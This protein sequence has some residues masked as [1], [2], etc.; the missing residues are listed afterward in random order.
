L[1]DAVLALQD[2]T[3]AGIKL[4]A[5]DIPV[6]PELSA[7][8]L[9]FHV[10][11]FAPA[12]PSSRD[13]ETVIE[14][15]RKRFGRFVPKIKPGL[16]RN[17]RSFVRKHIRLEYKPLS[18]DADLSIVTWLENS[19]YTQK[20]KEELYFEY[21]V[22]IRGRVE[23]KEYWFLSVLYGR[24]SREQ[25]LD[26]MR[27]N[28]ENDIRVAVATWNVKKGLKCSSFIKRETY[29][30]FKHARWINSP[31]P[32]LKLLF[33]PICKAI[34][35][36]VFHLDK[37]FIKTIPVEDRSRYIHD[38]MSTPTGAYYA[39]DYSAFESSFVPEM[40]RACEMQ[41]YRYMVKNIPAAN[42]V[43]DI[44]ESILTGRRVCRAVSAKVVTSS[45]MSGDMCTSLGNGFT[46]YMVSKYWA[47]L[48]NFE[49]CGVVEGDDGVFR[50]PRE[51]LI[52][53]ESFYEDLGFVIKM[54][55]V[56][57]LNEAGFCKIFYAEGEPENL[58]EPISVVVKA[59]WTMSARMHGSP[60]TMKELARAKGNSLLCET[61]TCP[62][63]GALGLWLRRVT[64]GYKASGAENW[65]SR[66]CE[67]LSNL[68]ACIDRARRGPSFA[69]RMFVEKKWGVSVHDQLHIENYINSLSDLQPLDDPTLLRL[70]AA[71]LPDWSVVWHTL[72]WPRP[73][74]S[75]W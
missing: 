57:R 6:R 51:D 40:I 30:E 73:A 19:H 50:V 10:D 37:T 35:Q 64:E 13:P 49:Y 31:P 16:L 18:H 52:P 22:M 1:V 11:G 7:R 25:A 75:A 39:T 9:G 12:I 33:G 63:L 72:A 29:P 38:L 60:D 59:G 3:K 53:P 55:R 14:G 66:E 58:R 46:N 43:L 65:W 62:I 32:K 56:E 45:R 23:A 21:A 2:R 17:F 48:N 5:F 4:K 68:E 36:Y 24:G 44:V 71:V 27:E 42:S 47:Y 74:G 20:Q 70:S 69:Q 26:N 41:L 34:E 15:A 28:W 61:P 67:H 8:S 54:E